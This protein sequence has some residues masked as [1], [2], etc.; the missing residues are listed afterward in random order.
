MPVRQTCG[1]WVASFTKCWPISLSL[2]ATPRLISCSKFFTYLER[3]RLII[4]QKLPIYQVGIVNSP[5]WLVSKS[6]FRIWQ[7][8][9]YFLGTGISNNRGQ[10][11]GWS[12][13]PAARDLLLKMVIYDP[14]SRIVPCEAMLDVY[15][16]TWVPS[17]FLFK[18]SL[19]N[20]YVFGRMSHPTYVISPSPEVKWY[21]LIW[22]K[23]LI[24]LT[25]LK[26]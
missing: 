22:I 20:E 25:C 8:L 6:G 24:P 5:K 10:S 13:P 21:V 26:F 7:V 3:L 2:L 15:F 16:E 11:E 9:K 19:W 17:L 4:G 23:Y 1:H 12:I 14:N 18:T